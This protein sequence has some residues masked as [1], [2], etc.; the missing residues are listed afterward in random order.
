[1]ES[2]NLLEMF[3]SIPRFNTYSDYS[4]TLNRVFKYTS[5]DNLIY[6]LKHPK[7]IK[8]SGFFEDDVKKINSDKKFLDN[9]L[10]NQPVQMEE[11]DDFFDEKYDKKNLKKKERKKKNK[12]NKSVTK[13]NYNNDIKI[14]KPESPDLN[15]YNPNYNAIYKNIHSVKIVLSDREKQELINKKKNNNKSK[16][17]KTHNNNTENNKE[18]NT[19]NN[20]NEHNNND[21]KSK[22]LLTGVEEKKK[23]KKK[24]FLPPIIDKNN[25]A[26]KFESYT[27]RVFQIPKQNDKISYIEPYDYLSKLDKVIDFKKI[28]SRN[29]YG[30]IAPSQLD[31]PSFCYYRPKY[32]LVEKSS[33]KFKFKN[34]NDKDEYKNNKK[35]L[36]R[37]YIASYKDEPGYHII[38]T[39]K[40]EENQIDPELRDRLANFN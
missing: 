34:D 40:L 4:N 32:D 1:M 9:L 19:E 13:K 38:D 24:I 18:Y 33:I 39:K 30:L 6:N 14:Y 35:Y 27:N 25:H 28:R 3:G 26:I 37:K 29:E 23:N 22:I 11:E 10:D 21:N 16:I 20:N 36:M 15:K 31:T 8:S 12:L 5:L 7:I 2:D 17:L